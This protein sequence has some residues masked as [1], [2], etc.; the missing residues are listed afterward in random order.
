MKIDDELIVYLEELSYLRL[1]DEEKEQAK[2]DLGGII[3]YM[4]KLSGLNTDDYPALSHPFS[5]TNRFREDKVS[6]SYDNEKILANAPKK[7]DGCFAVP[8]TVEG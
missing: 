8:K 5:D 1:S 4:D 2:I 3:G 6:A 7:V